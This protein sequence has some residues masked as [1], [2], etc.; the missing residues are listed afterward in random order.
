MSGTRTPVTGGFTHTMDGVDL[1]ALFAESGWRPTGLATV[2]APRM[3]VFSFSPGAAA[4]ITV[5][6]VSRFRAWSRIRTRCRFRRSG[7]YGAKFL[8]CPRR[9]QALQ[10]QLGAMRARAKR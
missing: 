5:R 1:A 2:V 9:F 6:W 7:G 3:A 4:T 8:C 10:D